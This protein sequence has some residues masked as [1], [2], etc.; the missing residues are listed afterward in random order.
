MSFKIRTGVA[1][2]LARLC[3]A[4][5]V[6]AQLAALVH[7]HKIDGP[8][9]FASQTQSAAAGDLCELCLLEFY[10]PLNP[11]PR[12]TIVR[13]FIAPTF[14]FVRKTL[15]QRNSSYD[16]SATRAPPALS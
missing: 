13:P 4:I 9:R 2:F 14:V 16:F 1:A 5:V 3:V 8:R 11:P 15:F 7:T 12:P 10:A 6:A